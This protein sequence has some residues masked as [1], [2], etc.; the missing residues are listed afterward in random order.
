MIAY[1][2]TL[3]AFSGV[4]LRADHNLRIE[5]DTTS[6]SAVYLV[7]YQS[8]YDSGLPRFLVADVYVRLSDDTPDPLSTAVAQAQHV[9]QDFHLLAVLFNAAVHEPHVTGVYELRPGGAFVQ[10][11]LPFVRPHGDMRTR[12]FPAQTLSEIFGPIHREL[13]DRLG[14]ALMMYDYSICALHPHQTL[15]AALRLYPGIENLTVHII[16]RLQRAAGMDEESHAKSLGIDTAADGWTYHYRG[17]VRRDHIFTEEPDVFRGLRTAR[18]EYEHASANMED[19]R[20]AVTPILPSL[21]RQVRRA[22]LAELP[23]TTPASD[24]LLGSGLDQPLGNWPTRISTAGMFDGPPDF[25]VADAPRLAL[26]L[27]AGDAR[28]EESGWDPE[29]GFRKGELTFTTHSQASSLPDG[30]TAKVSRSS[31]ASPDKW[32]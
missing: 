8:E 9:V 12:E 16:K 28:F 31:V 6:T 20:N 10:Q 14:A 4:H 18:N 11:S 29:T 25:F 17:K 27:R 5:A 32:G 24:L 30:V 13:P 26:D 21:Y 15:Q 3:K 23:L 19:I 22:L 2:V 1:R 7:S